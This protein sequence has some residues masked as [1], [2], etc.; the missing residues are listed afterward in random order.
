MLATARPEGA[1]FDFSG[2]VTAAARPA[3]NTYF[4]TPA[5]AVNGGAA[6]Y[7]SHLRRAWALAVCFQSVGRDIVVPAWG[8]PPSGSRWALRFRPGWCPLRNRSNRRH[9]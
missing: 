4:W 9:R 7:V 2:P 3:D 1:V 5:G 6:P 8:Y